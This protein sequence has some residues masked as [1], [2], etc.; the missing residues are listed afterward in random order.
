MNWLTNNWVKVLSTVGAM[1]S[2]LIAAVAGGMF[3][4]V[5][6][7][8]DITWLGII[9][10]FMNAFLIGVGFNN[11]TQQKIAAA[12][13][14]AINAQPPKQSGRSLVGMLLLTLFLCLPIIAVMPGCST[15]GIPVATTFNQRALSAYSTVEG[16]A[17][18]TNT[19]LTAGKLSRADAV[20]VLEQLKNCK[21]ALD[22]ATSI[23]DGA[24]QLGEDKLQTTLAVLQALQAYV[25]SV[26]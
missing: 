10:F 3:N 22:V 8:T 5:M 26:K 6:S 12:M 23:H 7:E 24:P 13:Q 14:D 17:N 25:G 4:K 21:T 11:T 15:L 1:N 18:A 20:N 2:A 9:G 16:V 19:L